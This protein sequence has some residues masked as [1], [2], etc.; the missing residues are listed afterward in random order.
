MK[1]VCLVSSGG[2]HL[3][4]LKQLYNVI[5]KNDTF[6]VVPSSKATEN[7]KYKKHLISDVNRD[8]HMKF[9]F[10]LIQITFQSILIYIKERPDIVISTGALTALPMCVISKAFRKKLIFIESFAR[11]ET[12]NKSGK[13]AYKIADVFI[14]Q[15]PELQKYYPKAIYGG[16]IY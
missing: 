3:E 6:F 9:I 1:K 7:M 16:W 12:P 4:Q 2:G 11:I 10:S 15:W 5:D 14:I 13:F 8:G